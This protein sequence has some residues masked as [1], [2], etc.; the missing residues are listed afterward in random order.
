MSTK[1]YFKCPG[2]DPVSRAVP[3]MFVC[4]DCGLEVEIWTDELKGKCASCNRVFQKDRIDIAVKKK[5]YGQNVRA[6]LKK[7]AQIAY[8]LGANDARAISTTDISVEEDLA[9]LCREPGCENYGLSAGCPPHVAGP[10]GFRKSLKTFEHALVF[11][12]DVPSEILFS[13]ERRDIFRL[14]HEIAAGIEQSAIEMGFHDSSAYAG[15][16]CKQIFCRD[17]PD[18]RV[19]AENSECRNPLFARPSMS[20]FGIN[21]LKLKKAAGWMSNKTSQ[22]DDPDTISM[23]TVCG[24]ILIG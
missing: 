2:N 16:S 20:G 9:K 4:P 17:Y 7:L 24:L 11:K 10:A 13:D 6:V 1:L 3:E 23:Q 19:L 14:L 22:N 12:I 18:C 5:L 15:G 21:V 8:Q